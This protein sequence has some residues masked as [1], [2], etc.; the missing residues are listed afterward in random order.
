MFDVIVIGAGVIGVS[1]ARA[2]A[3]RRPSWKIAVLEKEADVACHT[4]GRN[5]GVVH[6]GFNPT[7]AR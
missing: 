1:F 6:S 3:G 2:L 4:G 7:S 5:S